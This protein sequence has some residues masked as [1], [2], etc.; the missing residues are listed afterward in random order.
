MARKARDL[1]P[2]VSTEV[3]DRGGRCAPCVFTA[4]PRRVTRSSR[5]CQDVQTA[6]RMRRQRRHHRP[7]LGGIP[8][9]MEHPTINLRT[10]VPLHPIDSPP[11][12]S[13]ARTLPCVMLAPV[14][15]MRPLGRASVFGGR[16][17]RTFTRR[18]PRHPRRLRRPRSP[19]GF[20]PPPSRPTGNPFTILWPGLVLLR[21]D[22]HQ[23]LGLSSTPRLRASTVICLLAHPL[24]L[25]TLASTP[26]PPP[27]ISSS[28]SPLSHFP[29]PL[30]TISGVLLCPSP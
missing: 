3:L 17:H 18:R 10:V 29:P 2:A 7:L 14:N 30:L 5:V 8:L 24:G 15:Q 9:L 26:P 6:R 22:L 12:P 20:S 23:V 13:P 16:R 27:N 25:P 11:P 1:V 19:S 4:N 28:P 21:A